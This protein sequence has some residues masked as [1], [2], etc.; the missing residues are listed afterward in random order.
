MD[1]GDV[2]SSLVVLDIPTR[3]VDATWLSGSLDA[4]RQPD[5]WQ[6][7]FPPFDASSEAGASAQTQPDGRSTET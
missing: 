4:Y 3:W 2:A 5:R 7:V 6:V 1:D